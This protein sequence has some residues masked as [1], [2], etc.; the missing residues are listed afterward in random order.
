MGGAE[1]CPHIKTY[2]VGVKERGMRIPALT[3]SALTRR[4]FV[5]G[6]GI[7]ATSAVVLAAC[8]ESEPAPAPAAAAP[9]AAAPAA[10]RLDKAYE[11]TQPVAIDLV[12]E[13]R[14]SRAL[15][16]FRVSRQS[17]QSE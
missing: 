10:A 5:A 12:C 2:L 8:G 9:A 6:M 1:M 14:R 3:G 11:N 15:F 7:G 13:W 17:N 16:F 4:R